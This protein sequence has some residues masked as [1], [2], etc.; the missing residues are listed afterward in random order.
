VSWHLEN[1]WTGNLSR[2]DTFR[3]DSAVSPD[4]YRVQSTDYFASGFDRGHMTPNADRDNP[5]TIPLNQ[6]T[7]LMSNMVP[8]APNNNQGP[9]ADLEAFLR[10]LLPANEV[11]IVAGPAG[12]AV[13]V[14][15]VRQTRLRTATSRFR[16]TR[17]KSR[18]FCRPAITTSRA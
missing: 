7:F 13:P 15:M 3:A 6:E 2:V 4:W 1:D 12:V 16:L 17:G 9:W 10:T 18:W 11:Y 8:Q 5:A 14:T